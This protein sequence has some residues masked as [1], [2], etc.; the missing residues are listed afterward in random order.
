MIEHANMSLCISD[1]FMAAVTADL[2]W[3]LKWQGRV[4][5]TVR[6]RDI[7]DQI[8]EAAWR[9]AEPGV[10]FM[11]RAQEQS[12]MWYVENIRCTNPCVTGDTLVYTATGLYPIADLARMG[13]DI[14]VTSTGSGQP[15]FE[16]AAAASISPL[17]VLMSGRE[18]RPARR[19]AAIGTGPDQAGDEGGRVKCGATVQQRDAVAAHDACAPRGR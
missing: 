3:D 18:A 10:V 19:D 1:S 7:W 15:T 6:A 12:P 2:P 4:V 14:I 13:G 16:H 8:V 11:Q 9:T 5:R 17:P